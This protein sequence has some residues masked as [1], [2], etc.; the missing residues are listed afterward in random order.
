MNWHFRGVFQWPNLIMSNRRD[1]K[2]SWY[3]NLGM[4]HRKLFVIIKNYFN[5]GF[6]I[7]KIHCEVEIKI[8]IK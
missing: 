1:N 3:K 6:K 4:C 2:D 5:V 8:K 7:F